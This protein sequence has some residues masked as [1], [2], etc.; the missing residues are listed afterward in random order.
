MKVSESVEGMTR[1]S[2]LF[3]PLSTAQKNTEALTQARI[4]RM[5]LSIFRL[6]GQT[7]ES[8]GRGLID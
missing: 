5:V 6:R 8:E 4:G 7:E 1:F 2:F 3:L